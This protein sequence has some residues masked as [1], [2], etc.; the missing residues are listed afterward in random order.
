MTA[1]VLL[2]LAVAGGLALP[3]PA[4]EPP[5]SLAA[6]RA[7]AEKGDAASQYELAGRY[8]YGQDVEK[9]PAE[10]LKWLRRAA[11][12][13]SASAQHD[14]GF[15]YHVGE[16]VPQDYAEAMRWY[17]RAAEK[18]HAGAQHNI[19]ELY[20]EGKGV[21][22][23]CAEAAR[24]FRLAAA[25]E[26]VRAEYHLGVLHATGCGV[27]PDD[28]EAVRWYRLAAEGWH[29][30]AQLNLGY[31]YH[32]GRG[33]PRDRD[34]AA[35]WLRRPWARSRG[36][37]LSLAGTA[38]ASGREADE[39]RPQDDVM[40][41]FYFSAA[42][43]AGESNV[44]RYLDQVEGRLRPEQREEARQLLAA[45]QRRAERTLED[46]VSFLGTPYP[47][48]SREAQERVRAAGQ[49]AV[50]V[51]TSALRTAGHGPHILE[52]SEAVRRIG[53]AA[54]DAAPALEAL[55]ASR[56]P[57]D[58]SR[59]FVASALAR[60]DPKRGKAHVPELERC[61][62]SAD[63]WR[64]WVRMGC[65]F[66]LDD[67]ESQS[68]PTRLALLRDEDAGMRAVAARGLRKGP[69][70][71]VRGPLEKA[72]RDPVLDVR[73]RAASSLLLAVPDA[74]ASAL[75]TLLE[76]L[77]KG[78]G[79]DADIA[80]DTLGDMTAET[81][82]RALDPLAGSLT[83]PTCQTWAAV[84]IG[85][86]EPARAVPVLGLLRKAL[87]SEDA[88]LRRAAA[89][90]LGG[91][92]P[93][94]RDAVA[95]LEEAARNDPDLAFSLDRLKAPPPGLEGLRLRDVRLVGLGKREGASVAYLMHQTG[96]VWEARAGQRL[97][98][99]VVER[100]HGD[101]LDFVGEGSVRTPV[102]LFAGAA[103][104]PHGLDPRKYTGDPFSIDL[105]ADVT[106]F[107]MLMGQVSG[108]NLVLEAGTKGP[109]RFAARNAPWDGVLER[110]LERAGFAARI[111]RSYVRIGRQDRMARMR[112]LSTRQWNGEPISVSLRDADVRDIARLFTHLTELPVDLSPPEPY[113]RVTLLLK[114]VPWDAAFDLIMASY[115]W[116]WRVDGDRIRVEVPPAAR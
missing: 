51:L 17:R 105:D 18:R 77:C 104:A 110:A 83:D 70:A 42:L 5:E 1:R 62:L 13:G 11:E 49:E 90:T 94:A 44:Q 57:G 10:S 71:A 87:S 74:P 73:V 98:D 3:A 100:V 109:V 25:Q 114:D 112:P 37:A 106:T 108:L 80:A 27:P 50:P 60:V 24:W 31:M 40:A 113:E 22:K 28:A 46:W 78:T 59:P 39:G 35:K 61:S 4:A 30:D 15:R 82:R 2:V 79:T 102:V 67:V 6:L 115:G 20:F 76:G 86:V 58:I 99:G 88:S 101:G 48:L 69:A 55:L 81:A 91:M 89:W 38:F 33:V 66:A 43:A 14:L 32:A 23:D 93:L 95:D 26:D 116:T 34:E 45:W 63:T 97:Y 9:D 84:A 68:W 16:G 41:D 111:D 47:T 85:R 21:P 8:Q 96:S 36:V 19:G 72:L 54:R 7:A 75:T 92:G 29:D 64:S 12:G 103:P 53:P 65:L 52:L 56:P 107:A